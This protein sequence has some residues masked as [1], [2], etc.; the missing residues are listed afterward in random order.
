MARSRKIPQ[1]DSAAVTAHCDSSTSAAFDECDEVWLQ[2]GQMVGD[3]GGVLSSG[4]MLRIV[5][6]PID[7][8]INGEM[9]FFLSHSAAQ[10]LGR[11]LIA[12]GKMQD[13]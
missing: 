6:V 7:G 2:C 9:I 10:R 8:R 12:S 13:A 11:K 4:V 5:D 1:L 3:S